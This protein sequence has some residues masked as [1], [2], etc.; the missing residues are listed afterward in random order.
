MS[1]IIK[2]LF[3]A[4]AVFFTAGVLYSAPAAA[5]ANRTWVSGVGDDLN[6]CS[7]TAP[8]KTF[9]GAISKTAAG[10]EI[11]C[12]DPAGFGAV[13]VTKSITIDCEDT[14]GAILAA[15]T[16]GVIVNGAN[17]DVVLRGISINAGPAAGLGVNGVRMLQG[18][19]L[20]LDQVIISNFSAAAPNGNAVLINPSSGTMTVTINDS[21]LTNNLNGGVL[22]APTGAATVNLVINRSQIIRNVA[23]VT[24]NSGGFATAL[25]LSVVDSTVSGGNDP[26]ASGVVAKTAS[27]TFTGS[28]TNSRIVN[29]GTF[30]LRITGGTLFVGGNT[31]SGNGTGVNVGGGSMTT[32]GNNLLNGNAVNGT[33]TTTVSPS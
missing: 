4:L 2:R 26:L 33:F 10:G 19:S 15:G 8:C 9:A 11:N 17:V 3:L 7:R 12:L 5:Q 16:T 13:T 28:V 22:V 29:N 1:G 18:R 23:G 25:T 21:V 6:P 20:L 31:I 14:Q 30:G 27:G 24:L 32:F